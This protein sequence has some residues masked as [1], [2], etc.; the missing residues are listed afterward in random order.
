MLCASYSL[1]WLVGLMAMLLAYRIIKKRTIERVRLTSK[2]ERVNYKLEK[3]SCQDGLT[4]VAN[5][6]M[7]DAL[8]KREQAL[9]LAQQCN[10]EIEELKIP[11]EHSEAADDD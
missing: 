4:K 10:R 3:F 11:H 8:L 6:R 5:R 9:K 1:I 7:F 2:L